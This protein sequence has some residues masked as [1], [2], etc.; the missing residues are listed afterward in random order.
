MRFIQTTA[1]RTDGPTDG[2]AG[3]IGRFFIFQFLKNP[4]GDQ[5]APSLV[6]G[7]YGGGG[8][9]PTFRRRKADFLEGRGYDAAP[10]QK[11]V[12]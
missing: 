8:R 9:R 5:I 1:G 12:S 7:P 2:R 11:M 3:A 10:P 4:F 6:Q